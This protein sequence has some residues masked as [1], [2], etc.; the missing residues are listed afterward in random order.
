MI[1]TRADSMGGTAAS[2]VTLMMRVKAESSPSWKSLRAEA[3]FQM[4]TLVIT[5]STAA[6]KPQ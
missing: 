2:M 3:T 4:V 5:M 1:V 6:E